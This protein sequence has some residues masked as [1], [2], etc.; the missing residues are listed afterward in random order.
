M[1][2]VVEAIVRVYMF[3]SIYIYVCVLCIYICFPPYIYT[4]MYVYC[5][6]ICVLYI[7]MFTSF[8]KLMLR[9]R[10]IVVSKVCIYRLG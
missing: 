4:Y 5:I 8:F 3:F 1:L 9:V 6:Y 2:R 10:N 7:Y